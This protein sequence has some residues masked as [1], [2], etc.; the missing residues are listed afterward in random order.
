MSRT[1]SRTSGI[2]DALQRW[3]F[4]GLFT[5]TKYGCFEYFEVTENLLGHQLGETFITLNSC[6]DE[7]YKRV[8]KRT[9]NA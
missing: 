7:N 2:S 5:Q 6:L 8:E 4:R 9:K 1:W 3:Q